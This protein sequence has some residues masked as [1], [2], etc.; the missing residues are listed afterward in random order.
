MIEA[1][2]GSGKMFLVYVWLLYSRIC[3]IF[4]TM[5]KFGDGLRQVGRS[6]AVVHCI[7]DVVFCM[8]SERCKDSVFLH[9]T[10]ECI[11]DEQLRLEDCTCNSKNC[12]IGLFI[13]Y[14]VADSINNRGAELQTDKFWLSRRAV[15]KGFLMAAS[16]CLPMTG[17][18]WLAW[19]FTIS[20][21]TIN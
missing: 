19:W 8:N 13:P 12:K 2:S 9:I 5:T 4:H 7:V 16:T 14:H 20:W 6:S 3:S 21:T 18:T 11:F 10:A 15:A 17:K 1:V